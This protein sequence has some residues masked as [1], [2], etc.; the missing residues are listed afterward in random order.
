MKHWSHSEEVMHRRGSG[1]KNLNM[2]KLTYSLYEN[3]YRNL[4]Y[5]ILLFICAYKAWVISPPCPHLLPYHPL[6]PSLSPHPL[7]CHKKGT[8]VE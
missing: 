5:F 6:C 1:T 7:N 2:V 3:E 8:K 4:F